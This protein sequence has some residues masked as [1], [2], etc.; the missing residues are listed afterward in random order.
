LKHKPSLTKPIKNFEPDTGLPSIKT[1]IEFKFI[2]DDKAAKDI[3]EEILADTRGYYSKEWK[4]F[5]YVIYE[6]HRIRPES[7]WNEL[8][9]QCGVD[10]NT[11]VIV[12]CGTPPLR[13]S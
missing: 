5:L 11:N 13:L 6:T 9:R 8:L 4:Q 10:D 7:E 2:S 1:L 12:L 3:A